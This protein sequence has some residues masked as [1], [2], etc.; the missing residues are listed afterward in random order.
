MTITRCRSQAKRHKQGRHCRNHRHQY[1]SS[2]SSPLPS[3]TYTDMAATAE[4]EASLLI[5][6]HGA[7]DLPKADLIGT[8]DPFAVINFPARSK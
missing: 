2:S 1:P 6:L 8:S 7:R 3:S 4:Y 5:T